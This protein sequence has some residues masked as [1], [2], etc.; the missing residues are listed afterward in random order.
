[1]KIKHIRLTNF[2]RHGSLD[3]D[4][5]A[6]VVGIR[7]PNGAGKSTLLEALKYAVTSILEDNA[8]TYMRDGGKHGKTLVE[9]QFG[10][11]GKIG[12]VTRNITK[13]TSG[14]KLAWDGATYTSS[15]EVDAIMSGLL[16][17]DKRSV[18]NCVFVPQGKLTSVLFG[19]KADREKQFLRMTGCAHFDN[20]A[21]A[22]QAQAAKLRADVQDLEPA[23][24]ELMT[25][26][27]QYGHRFHELGGQMRAI[28]DP[29][30]ELAAAN[31]YRDWRHRCALAND[32][33]AGSYDRV[34]AKLRTVKTDATFESAADLLLAAKE[35][36]E[37]ITRAAAA[38]ETDRQTADAALKKLEALLAVLPQFQRAKTMHEEA[39]KLQVPDSRQEDQTLVEQQIAT[40]AA[41]L[42]SLAEQTRKAAAYRQDVQDLKLAGADLQTW[43]EAV[44]KIQPDLHSVEYQLTQISNEEATERL[45][46]MQLRLNLMLQYEKWETESHTHTHT[47]ECPVCGNQ[48]A[49]KLS[50]EALATEVARLRRE[51]DAARD[52]R[53]ALT[54]RRRTLQRDLENAQS[55]QSVKSN[56]V[57]VLSDRVAAAEKEGLHLIA[58]TS[59]QKTE[60]ETRLNTLRTTQQALNEEA[61]TRQ[62]I[63]A[64]KEADRANWMTWIL[65]PD[66]AELQSTMD[67][68]ASERLRVGA[69]QQQI[70]KW[71][72]EK[73]ALMTE[74]LNSENW[75][76]EVEREGAAYDLQRVEVLNL[77]TE[78]K[79][80]QLDKDLVSKTDDVLIAHIQE[81]E[82]RQRERA[83]LSSGREEMQNLITQAAGRI[84]ELETKQQSFAHKLALASEMDRVAEVFGKEGVTKHYLGDMYTL[85][86]DRVGPYLEK[87]NAPFMVRKGEG[88]LNFEF[89]RTD[90][91][92][93]WMDQT[94]LSGGQRVKMAV[95]FLLAL[96]QVVIPDVGLLVLDE[97]T[98]HLD[99]E[100]REGFRDLLMDM[101]AMLE[102][103]ECQ[104][105][106]C[107]HCPEIEA[108]LQKVVT[109][110]PPQ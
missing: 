81:L 36:R 27:E 50:R 4:M 40:V 56:R 86:L 90:E 31:Y 74:R 6:A 1:M 44:N 43:H 48:A 38:L 26:Q 41:S 98:T 95:S 51:L 79:H 92:S 96:Q 93:E 32:R 61:R 59:T 22:A 24:R 67:I 87:A 99:A 54:D 34:L 97:P 76:L 46:M 18:L 33:R 75:T 42:N 71:R 66:F 29:T 102:R 101:A 85:I 91:E 107:D 94:K 110:L 3:C 17:A 39:E 7:G 30:D 109:I 11:Y 49:G 55:Q 63:I 37:K 14:R 12:D 60:L 100:S 57:G 16:N 82:A 10:K 23:L 77:M 83:T 104:V 103:T 80:R 28:M 9:M 15:K 5:D 19:D 35:R 58:D 84:T 70:D 62:N 25:N 2:G 20:V 72:E 8:N 47:A 78:L 69:L 106:V 45:G 65:R 21:K 53:Q 105:I 73:Q 68:E 88:V 108:A 64:R 89:M 13:T 52:A